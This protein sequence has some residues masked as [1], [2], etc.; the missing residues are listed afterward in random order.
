M[1][2]K[3]LSAPSMNRTKAP[4]E[5]RKRVPRLRVVVLNFN[6]G[7]M[8]IGC[9][10]ALLECDTAGLDVEIVLV[11]NA[12]T[13]GVAERVERDRPEV[14]VIRSATNL[15]FAGGNNLA[16]ADLEGVD[17]VALVNND[18][19]VSRNWLAPLVEAL[20]GDDALGAA[21][22]KMLLAGRYRRLDLACAPEPP[23]RGD[24]R[25]RG[26]RV[27]DIAGEPGAAGTVQFVDGFY[28]PEVDHG[29]VARWTA[30]R[31]TAFVPV[32][33]ESLGPSS[34]SL[35]IESARDKTVE[36]VSGAARSALTVRAGRHRYEVALDG[37]PVDVVNNLGTELVADD[38]GA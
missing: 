11:D 33:A 5:P 7:D 30:P 21:S 6:G 24:G 15:G 17:L 32:N 1:V 37:S 38:Y 25:Q 14:R 9:L 34:C 35:T 4:R 23:W 29:P 28:E 19:T 18:V 13:D 10:D 27:L 20:R 3:C 8:T 31:C 12:S 36:A 2:E 26:V 16:L 22:P